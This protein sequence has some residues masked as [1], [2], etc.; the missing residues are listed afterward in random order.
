MTDF[1]ELEKKFEDFEKFP[2]N[3]STSEQRKNL[4]RAIEDRI[5]SEVEQ[6]M[7]RFRQCQSSNMVLSR[8][9]AHLMVEHEEIASTLD[10]RAKAIE[11]EWVRVQR[12]SSGAVLSTMPL[13]YAIRAYRTWLRNEPHLIGSALN[14][15]EMFDQIDKAM[16]LRAKPE[17]PIRNIIAEL[18]RMFDEAR[19][20]AA[21][22]E[23]RSRRAFRGGIIGAL[24]SGIFAVSVAL[25]TVWANKPWIKTAAPAPCATAPAAV[26]TTPAQR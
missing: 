15:E 2:I 12:A 21:G 26:P 5:Q 18:K 13:Y 16:S 14:D 23:R 7:T 19:R 22:E 10:R 25:I 24:I 6:R 3:D 9:A 8:I 4:V 20:E 11:E 1:D 17:K